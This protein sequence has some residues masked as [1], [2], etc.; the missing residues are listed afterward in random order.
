M[1]DIFSDHA[2]YFLNSPKLT[3][4][5]KKAY[6]DIMLC[7]TAALG[8]H[9]EQCNRCGHTRPAYNSCRNRNCPKCQFI[10]K[11]LWVDK[12]SANLPPVRHFH[13]VFTIPH[14]LNKLFY[15]NQKTA[16]DALFS[17]A[18]KA[19]MQCAGNQ[20]FLGAQAGAAAILHTWGQALTYHP[21]IHMIVPAGGLS[22]DE[23]EWV[24]AARSFFVPVK[25]LS[26]VFR[27]ILCRL[28][29]QQILA[30]MIKL[31]DETTDFKTLKQKCYRKDWVVYAEKPF[32]SPDAL[33]HYLGN[34]THRVAITNHRIKDYSHGKVCFDY[35]DYRTNGIK[36]QMSLDGR[37]F[38]GRFLQH[39]LPSG[40]YKIR[41]FGFLAIC[42]IKTK[43]SA[44]I[45]LIGRTTWLPQL[46][47]LNA[48]E[49]I[50]CLS[51]K[52]PHRCPVCSSGR[53]C[54]KSTLA[55]V[56]IKPG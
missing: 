14:C 55:P 44:C 46:Q 33:I 3:H 39:V 27:G 24:P 4:V 38:I 40:F 37:E 43:L 50:R 49:I 20:K 48:M 6:N 26:R 15:L 36:R 52:D 56:L 11:A 8:G 17:A 9:L 12:L 18:G 32:N 54:A 22:E 28:I 16:Y 1:A 51:G 19:L 5:Q 34:Y 23:M 30:G 35:K 2:S 45:G 53:M 21:H 10:R 31:P 7:R 13:I 47:G 25:T 29:D 42:N 41:Y